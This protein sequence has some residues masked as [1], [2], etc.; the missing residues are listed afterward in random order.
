[1]AKPAPFI[2]RFGLWTAEQARRARAL[3]ALAAKHKLRLIRLVW[4]DTHGHAR[5]KEV[6]IP[7][8]LSAL[9]HGYNINVATTT[10]DASG[11][12]TFASFTPGGGM[13]LAEMTGSPNLTIVPDPATFRVLPWA[14][15]IGWVICDEYFNTG[16]PFHFSPRQVLKK[17][18]ARL[19]AQK[20]GLMVGLEVEWYLLR[21]AGD[22]ILPENTNAIG[23]KGKP[24]RTFP[25]ETGYS[26]HSESNF[27]IMQPVLSALAEH[28]EAIGLP[29]RSIENE[30]GPGQVECTFAPRDALTTADNLILFRSATR[31]IS[32]RMGYLA[33][34]MA[35]PAIPGF[36][37]SGWHLHQ[38]LSDASGR[39]NLFTPDGKGEPLSALGM[40]YLAGLLAHA[41]A[42]TPFTTP[43]VNGYR[44]Y[45]PNSLAPDRATWAYDHRGVMARVLGAAHDPATR[46]ENRIGEP[47]ANPYLYIAAQIVSGLDGI[48]HKREPGPQEL[49]P[50]NSDFP[51]LPKTLPEA[52]AALEASPLFREQF[53]ETFVTYFLAFKR[54]ELGRFEKW[55]SEHGVSWDAAGEPTEWEQNE[56]FDFF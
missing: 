54:T 15:G 49:N 29:L 44:R 37:A 2:E 16:I 23:F 13:G 24:V 33:T 56:Y 12:R 35:R 34:F 11:A 52:L 14:P 43:T 10:L 25:V 48:A 19:R 17:Q 1:M 42:A 21:L 45:K 20:F 50:Y 40:Q 53:G 6:T 3:K 18:L 5:T 8:F 32:R 38:S 55:K 30:W 27:D 46:I 39:R 31:Q 26:Y 28:F 4:S 36:C 51:L 22:P 9:V 41:Q 47:S 7:A